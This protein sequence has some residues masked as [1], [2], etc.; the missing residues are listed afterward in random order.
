M[1]KGFI[2]SLIFAALV[3]I[4]ALANA[5]KVAID[6]LFTKVQI[7]QAIVIFISTILGAV[8]VALLG[9]FKTLKLKKEI[10]ELNKQIEPLKLEKENLTSLLEERGEEIIKLNEEIKTIKGEKENSKSI[11]EDNIESI[12]AVEEI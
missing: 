4:F 1:E 9:A 3:A 2:F 6:F 7:S 11:F 5:D 10:K 12:E 8:I